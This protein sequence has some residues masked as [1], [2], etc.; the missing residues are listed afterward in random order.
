MSEGVRGEIESF[1]KLIQAM[2]PRAGDDFE[3]QVAYRLSDARLIRVVARLEDDVSRRIHLPDLARE[4][5]LSERRLEMIFKRELGMTF[6]A[7]YRELR[8]RYA[9]VSLSKLD[10]P[11]KVIAL[12]LGYSSIEAMDRE[13]RRVEGCTPSEFRSGFAKSQ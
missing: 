11:I 1:G 13:F 4:V 2:Q 3:P 7:F 12:Q 5:G 6:V 10:V 8:M 9:R